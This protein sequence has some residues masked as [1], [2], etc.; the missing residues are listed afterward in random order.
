[1]H[2]V[3]LVGIIDTL[4]DLPFG[5]FHCLLTLAFSLFAL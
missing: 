4:D 3:Q 2:S 1:D 5:R